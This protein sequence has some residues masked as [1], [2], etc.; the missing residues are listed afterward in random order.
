MKWPGDF[1]AIGQVE[2]DSIFDRFGSTEIRWNVLETLRGCSKQAERER[3][4]RSREAWHE[5]GEQANEELT[6][7]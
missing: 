1:D 2:P 5:S 4:C 6:Q 7:R 3:P